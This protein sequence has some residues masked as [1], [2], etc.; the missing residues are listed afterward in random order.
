MEKEEM[1][2]KKGKSE[3][4]VLEG[5]QEY[6]DQDRAYAKSHILNSICTEPLEVAKQAY[7]KAI[8][9]NL[10]DMRL[11][12]GATQI[13]EKLMGQLGNLLG[14]EHAAGSVVSGGTEANLLAM[15]VAKQRAKEIENPE[16]IVP[17]SI[18]FSIV[19]A[20]TLLGV[21]LVAIKLD[22]N[23]RAI[24][25][26]IERNITENT[27]AVFV[28]AGTSETGAIDP[29]AQ[30]DEI[31]DKHNLYLHVDAASGGFMIPFAKEVGVEMPQFDFSLKSVMSMTVDPHKY[32]LA[33]IPAG[34][35][36]FRNRELQNFIHFESFF[37]GTPNHKT[38]IGTRS[39]A[40]A[41]SAYAVIEYLGRSGFCEIVKHYINLK[42]EMQSLLAQKNM[43]TLGESDLN[44]ILIKSSHPEETMRAL[45]R[46]GWYV[47]VSKRY[48]AI[49]IVLHCHNTLEELKEF[50]DILEQL[51]KNAD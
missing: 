2:P 22:Q 37:V 23:F 48:Q 7:I 18:H 45:E 40:G 47:S 3:K 16:V 4:A 26:E 50:A 51:E 21:K 25:D 6:C 31:C 19:K 33:V 5:I 36:L 20:S 13:E 42:S 28:T 43:E 27:I 8:Y 32:G 34:F 12:P 35:I 15:F 44:I 41:A 14:N 17:E 38:F 9:T 29:I 49:R 46:C 11:F 30:I 24:P 39:A 10:G 1:F